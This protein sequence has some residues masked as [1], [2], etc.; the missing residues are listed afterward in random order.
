MESDMAGENEVLERRKRQRFI[1][2]RDG[3]DCFWVSFGGE[4]LP[5]LDLSLEGFAVPAAT[6]PEA[7]REFDFVLHCDGVVEEVR[8]Q[9]RVV[10]F[11]A[12][13]AGGQAGC[14]FDGFEGEGAARLQAWLSDHVQA[15][16]A[17]PV[18]EDEAADIV[19]GPSL[20]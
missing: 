4:R 2:R 15:V 17:L 10:N 5:V 7:N 11:L 9:A 20:V 13:A 12:S 14:L 8:G 1:A 18:T 16:S 6:P 19:T 3:A